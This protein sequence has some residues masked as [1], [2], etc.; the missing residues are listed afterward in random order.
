MLHCENH[1]TL[2]RDIGMEQCWTSVRNLQLN[3]MAEAFVKTFER[4]HVRI[5]P[6]PDAE[7]VMAQLL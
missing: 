6:S 1:P 2:L 3:R 5:N 4:D 7:I